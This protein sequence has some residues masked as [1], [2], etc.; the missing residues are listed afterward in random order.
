MKRA[1]QV[2]AVAVLAAVVGGAAAQAV[3]AD[4]GQLY[5]TH[6]ASCHGADR[7]GGTGPALLPES[8]ERL[9]KPA[10]A[11][12][13]ANGRIATQ[14]P[15]FGATL[16]KTDIDAL[17]YREDSLDLKISAPSLAVLSQLSQLI[18]KQGMTAEIESSQPV[19]G[20]VE[21]HIR[22][23]GQTAKAHP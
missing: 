18:G 1:L 19:A 7:F 16:A 23:R 9:R 4:G 6:C 14:M 15:A 3:T 10:A 12:A 13:I 8:L 21:A 20:G 5:A 22:L 11:D 17:S 2:A